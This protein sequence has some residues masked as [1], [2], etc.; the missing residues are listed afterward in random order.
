MQC[1]CVFRCLRCLDPDH[2]CM[3]TRVGRAEHLFAS[4]SRSRPY[5]E[6]WQNLSSLLRLTQRRLR[7]AKLSDGQTTSPVT[8]LTLLHRHVAGTCLGPEQ[9]QPI[10]CDSQ[11]LVRKLKAVA[12][13][14]SWWTPRGHQRVDRSWHLNGF[15]LSQCGS[16][17]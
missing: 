1:I 7:L 15:K 11:S 8:C 13:V 9:S 14:E 17:H 2:V 4:T 5:N 10:W 16:M 12:T 6:G 3:P